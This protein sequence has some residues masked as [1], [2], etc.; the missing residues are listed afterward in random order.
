MRA[1]AASRLLDRYISRYQPAGVFATVEDS[2]RSAV[3]AL[4][5]AATAPFQVVLFAAVFAS[6]GERAMLVVSMLALLV[7][8]IGLPVLVAT[9]SLRGYTMLGSWRLVIGGIAG[10]VLLGG[11]LWSGGYLWFGAVATVLAALVLPL[12]HTIA[13]GATTVAIALAFAPFE[14]W[15]R[16]LRDQPALGVSVFIIMALGMLTTLFVGAMILL[17]RRRLAVEHDRNRDLMLAILPESVADRLKVGP[18]MIAD[19]YDACTIVFA[20]LVGFTAHSKDQDPAVIVGQLN[21]IF[22]R[23]DALAAA[24]G[25]EKIKTIGD[26][27]M[28]ATGL[29]DPDPDHVR[30]ACDLALALVDAMPGINADLGTSF[31]LRVGL[32]TGPAIAGVV[33]STKFSYDVWGDTV[34]L[35]SRMESNGTPGLVVASSAVAAALR[36]GYVAVPLG[37]R[38]LKGQ[39]ETQFYRLDRAGSAR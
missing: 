30:H 29:P 21:T 2:R 31:Q 16:Q 15:F 25:A 32:H 26:G 33:G 8:L 6:N 14:G 24:H 35:A 17:L 7:D 28:A 3:I 18:G 27:Y 9:G 12:G 22:T 13:L 1:A 19:R 34:N 23:F 20:D 38:D 4:S 39:G 5:F 10:H 37:I 11:F 36:E